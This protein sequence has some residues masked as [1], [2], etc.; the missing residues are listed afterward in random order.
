MPTL[1]LPRLALKGSDFF[2]HYALPF[3]MLIPSA[4]AIYCVL[5]HK[6]VSSAVPAMC[7]MC[8]VTLA[9]SV[10]FAWYQTRALRFRLFQTSSNAHENCL[11]VLH[12][13][14]KEHWRVH[15]THADSQIVATVRGFPVTWGERVE[16]RFHGSDVFVNSICD[17][18]TFFAVF[19]WGRNREN[20]NYVGDAVMTSNQSLQPTA[21]RSDD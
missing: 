17:P 19:S 4:V 3:S 9:V 10:F 21:G 20:M 6:Y 18:G 14:H 2:T 12:A 11:K 15:Y 8:A 7:I 16:V 5:T 13:M 1:A